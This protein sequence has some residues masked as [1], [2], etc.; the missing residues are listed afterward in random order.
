MKFEIFS[1]MKFQLR[2][3]IWNREGELKVDPRLDSRIAIVRSMQRTK[4]EKETKLCDK[5]TRAKRTK[6]YDK[7]CKASQEWPPRS[8]D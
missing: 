7:D 2:R 6:E 1:M 4:L 8:G 3:N 5:S